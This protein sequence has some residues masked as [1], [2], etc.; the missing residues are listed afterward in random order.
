VDRILLPAMEK[1]RKYILNI[2]PLKIFS[3]RKQQSMN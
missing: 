2:I 3:R 1:K